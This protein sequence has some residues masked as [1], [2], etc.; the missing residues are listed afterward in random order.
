MVLMRGFAAV[1]TVALL[2]ATAYGCGGLSKGDADIRCNQ[3]QLDKTACF[4]ADVYAACQSCY[5]RCGDSCAPQELCPEQYL[6]PGDK[7]TG[8]GGTSSSSTTTTGGAIGTGTT[9]GS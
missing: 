8:T 3:E 6:C 2:A 1:A 7:L 5:E 9:T 4:D